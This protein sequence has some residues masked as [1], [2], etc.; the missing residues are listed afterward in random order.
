MNELLFQKIISKLNNINK[1]D[2]IL[3]LE[4]Y[5]LNYSILEEID[6]KIENIS[7]TFNSLVSIASYINNKEFSFELA[8]KIKDIQ[9]QKLFFLVYTKLTD[10]EKKSKRQLFDNLYK[11]YYELCEKNN[12]NEQTLS[13]LKTKSKLLEDTALTINEEIILSEL[14]IQEIFE[15]ANYYSKNF[16]GKN[17]GKKIRNLMNKNEYIFF[18]MILN[19]EKE[20]KIIEFVC[21]YINKTSIND[22]V[23]EF[24][25]DY[26]I[27]ENI[28]SMSILNEIRNTIITK[29]STINFDS[30]ELAN[31]NLI[32]NN[33][34]G[35]ALKFINLYVDGDYR[36]IKCFC[37]E[38]NLKISKFK[39]Y[40]LLV[41]QNNKKLYERYLLNVKMHENKRNLSND[42]LLNILINYIKNGIIK[43]GMMTEFT[44]EDYY[45]TINL[46]FEN[47]AEILNDSKIK[48]IEDLELLK[49][50]IVQNKAKRKH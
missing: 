23:Y 32:E 36:N 16:I 14:K 48:N 33:E 44:L 19:D 28:E 42:E 26:S 15:Y 46:P 47:I 20:E 31:S 21:R 34:V 6:F 7:L 24:I 50:F 41:S 12:W 40:I 35:Q 8:K 18:T 38:F 30:V 3:N 37:K 17:R 49:K 29:I 25:N 11:D 2:F 27:V 9:N 22:L 1:K 13:E 10:E 5:I 45:N 4:K 43:D 39:N